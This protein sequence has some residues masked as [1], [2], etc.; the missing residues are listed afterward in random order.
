MCIS[1]KLI[2]AGMFNFIQLQHANEFHELKP[3]LKSTSANSAAIVITHL[4]LVVSPPL[5]YM[6]FSVAHLIEL[7]PSTLAPLKYT[8]RKKF[9]FYQRVEE[10]IFLI[11]IGI[12]VAVKKFSP[13]LAAADSVGLFL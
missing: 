12:S 5:T 8:C 11:T 6:T 3:I 7:S 4:K 2:S 10:F 1:I 9:T 13:Y